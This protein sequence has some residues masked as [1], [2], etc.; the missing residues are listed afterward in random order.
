MLQIE[1]HGPRS[2]I[3]SAFILATVVTPIDSSFYLIT[4]ASMLQSCINDYI[5]VCLPPTYSLLDVYVAFG[6]IE[7]R[8]VVYVQV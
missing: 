1:V 5:I 2:I 3:N 8:V 7:L 4:F 6:S